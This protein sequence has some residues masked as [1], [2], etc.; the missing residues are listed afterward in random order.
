MRTSLRWISP[1]LA[2]VISAAAIPLAPSASALPDD[3]QVDA[4]MQKRI[5]NPRIGSDF[6]MVVIDGA[7]GAIVSSHDADALMLPASNM[8]IITAVNILSTMGSKGVLTTRARAGSAPNEVILEGGGDPMLSTSDLQDMATTVASHVDPNARVVVRVDDDLF[9]ATKRGPGWTTGYLPYVAAPVEALARLGDYSSDP[10]TNAAKVFTKR[11]RSLGLKAKLGDSANADPAAAVLAESTSTIGDAVA[12]MLSYS[13]NNVAEV[14]YRQVAIAKGHEPSWDGARVAAEQALA[15]LGIDATGMKLLDGSGLS[16]KDRVSA[17]FLA[18]V[19]RVA[20]I[21]NPGP[22]ASMFDPKALPVSGETGTLATAYGRYVTKHAR[23][24]RG[25]VHAKTGSLF[26]TISLSGVAQTVSG[27][28]R[29]FAFL[30]NDRPQQY[31]A[32]STR[33]ALDGLSATVTGCW[34]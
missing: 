25:D 2:L 8:K 26:D 13:E 32:L 33:Q 23:C 12:E 29:M 34:N 16:R 6:G 14:L 27:G 5:D 4:L 9:P 20:R 15:A 31:S 17:T 19:L 24:A 1:A 28:E 7:T 30:V 3:D 11:L 10:S 21:T 18:S 22:F